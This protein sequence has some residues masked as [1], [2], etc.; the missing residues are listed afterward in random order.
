MKF[1]STQA[2]LY[3][4]TFVLESFNDYIRSQPNYND[5]K[6]LVLRLGGSHMQMNFL[7]SIGHLMAGSGL[8]ELLEVV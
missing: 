2:Q 4:V 3:D 5:L 6:R 7:G 8:Q 1:E